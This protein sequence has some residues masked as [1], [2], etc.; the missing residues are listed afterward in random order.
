MS[1]DSLLYS[2]SMLHAFTK[3]T[4][5]GV[6]HIVTAKDFDYTRS[7]NLNLLTFIRCF[8]EAQICND[9]SWYQQIVPRLTNGVNLSKVTMTPLD[10]M[11][12]GYFMAML[13][14]AGGKVSVHLSRCSIDDYSLGLL[15]GEFS[16]Y[17]EVCPT[18]IMQACV[19]KLDISWNNTITEIGIAHVLRTN[20][21]NAL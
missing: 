2:S 18:G 1:L 7:S 19:T 11:S 15:V 5:Q 10:C 6:R 9:T 4:N 8:F 20:I 16:R 14:K 17:A 13:L 12:I 3:F 21:T